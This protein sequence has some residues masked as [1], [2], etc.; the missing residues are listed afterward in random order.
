MPAC[1]AAL[2]SWIVRTSKAAALTCSRRVTD[3]VS[4]RVTFTGLLGSGESTQLELS[5]GRAAWLHVARG[6]VRLNGEELRAG[7]GAG[8]H[9]E[10]KLTLEGVDDAEVVLWELAGV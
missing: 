10:T 1:S 9:A 4:G 2:A 8:I 3:H 6:R 5:E 7:G